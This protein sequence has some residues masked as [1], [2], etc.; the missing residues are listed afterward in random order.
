MA[1][2]YDIDSRLANIFVAEDGT[3]VD[4]ETGEILNAE[5]LEALDME[6]ND[7]IDN[8]ICYVKN[9]M[10]DA[11][12]YKA[13]AERQ[14]KRYEVAV[15]KAKSLTEYLSRH[16]EPG[17]KFTCAHGEIRW[18][19]SVASDFDDVMALPEE[20][21]KVEWK[22]DKAKLKADM[23]KGK[24]VPGARLVEKQNIQVK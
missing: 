20:Y 2:L 7:K 13:E 10:S 19:K 16:M 22:A 18:R 14:K 5:A 11:A 24:E 12:A 17:E 9:L 1:T 3:A 15:N 8:I 6:R 21:R 4:K 23:L